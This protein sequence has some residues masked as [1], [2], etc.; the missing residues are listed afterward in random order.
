MLQNSS[1][2]TSPRVL[3]VFR[4]YD[5]NEE[6]LDFLSDLLPQGGFL[7]VSLVGFEFLICLFV[8]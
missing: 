7:M 5:W 1:S 4:D 3:P 6:D 2:S 8:F